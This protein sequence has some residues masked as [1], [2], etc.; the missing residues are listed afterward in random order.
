MVIVPTEKSFDWQYTPAVLLSLVMINV[1]VFFLYQS[2]DNTKLM[3]AFASYQQQQLFDVEWPIY[4]K[5]L[6]ARDEQELADD[7]QAA[8]EEGFGVD[9]QFALLVDFD[10][11]SYIDANGREHFTNTHYEDWRNARAIINRQLEAI[12]FL[13]FGLIPNDMNVVSLVSHQFLHGDMMHLLGNMFFLVICGFAVEAA[14]GHLRFFLFYLITGVVGGLAYAVMDLKS[15][16]SLVGASDAI[17]GVMAMYLGVFRLRKIEFFYWFFVF[18]GYFRAPALLILPI[19][20]GKEVFDYFNDA[21]SNVA[22]MAHA[23]GFAAGGLL[24]IAFARITPTLINEE[25]VEEDQDSNPYQ[26]QLAKIYRSIENFQF[27]PARKALEAMIKE[28][29]LSF[30]LALL[31]Y[32]L[33]RIDKA[34][35]YQSAIDDLLGFKVS[36]PDQY[37]QQGRVWLENPDIHQS[38]GDETAV[39]IGLGL[40]TR[41][42]FGTAEQVLELLRGRNSQ[43]PQL[44]VLA[45]KLSQV[46]ASLNQR[47]K[48]KAY[49]QFADQLMT[50]PG[51]GNQ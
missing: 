44:G 4:R 29:G 20:I 28:H 15:G 2:G 9:V 17:S 38:L 18:V 32:N 39:N 37:G 48:Q 26:E 11:K 30:D 42:Q 7:Y 10:F 51:A 16:T 41:E 25:Y 43:H 50:A 6:V 13:N 33:L 34:Q 3:Q 19:Y 23:G 5:Y 14:I 45:R 47:R 22:F 12:S 31:R 36:R 40:A 46:A 49:E 24:M 8:I 35:G 21:G 1:L 27:R